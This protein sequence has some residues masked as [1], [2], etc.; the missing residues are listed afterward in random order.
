[1][2]GKQIVAIDVGSLNVVIAVGA[3]E[4]DGNI[5]IQGIVSEP[6][7]K[8]MIAGR[9]EN[10]DMVG[11]AIAAAK[12]RIEKQLN[13]RITEAYAGLAGDYVRCVQVV[14]AKRFTWT[15]MYRPGFFTK[16]DIRSRPSFVNLTPQ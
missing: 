14:S 16:Q 3:V 9:I 15:R 8:G 11:R 2:K 7:N 10:I 5:N 1:M 4:D 6:I 13:I 12:S